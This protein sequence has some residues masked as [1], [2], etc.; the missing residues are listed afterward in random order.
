MICLSRQRPLVHAVKHW[1]VHIFFFFDLIIF[2]FKDWAQ[3]FLFKVGLSIQRA[4]GGQSS[5]WAL[6]GN[7]DTRRARGH[8]ES[9]WALGQHSNGTRTRKKFRHLILR[10]VEHL[11][12]CALEHSR[13]LHTWAL[14]A[15]YSA[16]SLEFWN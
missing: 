14:E 15:L 10:V 2:P 8:S 13:R 4:D 9:T 1:Q 7:L 6:K 12:T 3:R 11:G 16:D 5:I